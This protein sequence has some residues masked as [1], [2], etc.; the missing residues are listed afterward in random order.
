MNDLL[1]ILNYQLLYDLGTRMGIIDS[2][3][4]VV[5]KTQDTILSV[6]FII[7][8]VVLLYGLQDIIFM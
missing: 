8:N 4:T 5:N 7:V 2:S 1:Y 6:V 3:Y